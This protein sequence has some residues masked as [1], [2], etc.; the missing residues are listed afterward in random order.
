MQD[1]NFGDKRADHH[2]NLELILS[3]LFNLCREYNANVL[4]ATA[5][6]DIADSNFIGM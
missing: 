6:R 3:I 2:V 4:L 5:A 1:F